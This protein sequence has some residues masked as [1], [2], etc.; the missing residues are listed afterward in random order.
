ME[1][2]EPEIEGFQL[3]LHHGESVVTVPAG[4]VVLRASKAADIADAPVFRAARDAAIESDQVRGRVVVTDSTPAYNAVRK[5]NPAAIL[6]LQRG[7]RPESSAQHHLVEAEEGL[8]GYPVVA[9]FDEELRKTLGELK[10]GLSDWKVSLHVSASHTTP[11][12][13]RNVIGLLSG[14]D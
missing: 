12:Q 13:V 4:G 8:S 6:H 10:P 5:L 14:S 9:I 1:D 7:R 11:A 3:T 2:V